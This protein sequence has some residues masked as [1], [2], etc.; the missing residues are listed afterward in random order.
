M[1][2]EAQH[3]VARQWCDVP[4]ILRFGG[5]RRPDLAGQHWRD[6]SGVRLGQLYQSVRKG[7]TCRRYMLDDARHCESVF[8]LML[9]FFPLRPG[10]GFWRFYSSNS[11]AI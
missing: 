1:V 5:S 8:E 11:S 2:G 9:L 6:A 3:C 4:E 7:V 10:H